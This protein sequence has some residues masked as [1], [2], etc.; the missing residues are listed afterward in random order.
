MKELINEYYEQAGDSTSPSQMWDFL[1]WEGVNKKLA[2]EL[3]ASEFDL[4]EE[5][6]A[7]FTEE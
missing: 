7:Y 2:F 4:D 5:E 3:V 6:I 1:I